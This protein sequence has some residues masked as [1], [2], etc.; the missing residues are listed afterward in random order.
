M[1]EIIPTQENKNGQLLISGRDLHE[2]LEIATQYTKWF[3]RM[4]EY[5]FVENTDFVTVSQ[6]SLIAN[7]GY[8]ER[9][10]HHLTVDMA[11]EIAMLQRSDRGKQA[12]HYFL[13]LERKWNS[14]EM[15]VKRAMDHLNAQIANLQTSNLLLEQQVNDLKP[16][17]PYDDVD[18]QNESLLSISEIA[19]ELGMSAIGLNQRLHDLGVQYK[20]GGVWYLYTKYQDK[21]GTQDSAYA[22]VAKKSKAPTK[23]TQRGRL[24]IHE[25][26]KDEANNK[27]A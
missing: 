11:K 7:G 1:N 16:Q 21:K 13:D 3:D 17:A 4:K 2:F 6:K 22:V 18:L 14:P 25:L 5:G 24:L 10:D 26:L 20:K 15:V 19:K 8:Q 9:I 12:R 23:W 27:E